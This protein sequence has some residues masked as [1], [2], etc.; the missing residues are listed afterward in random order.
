[1]AEVGEVAANKPRNVSHFSFQIDCRDE[2]HLVTLKAR[3]K[4]A[5]DHFGFIKHSNQFYTTS[6]YYHTTL[7]TSSRIISGI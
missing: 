7:S 2:E 5:K 3:L 1:M 6:K 4:W